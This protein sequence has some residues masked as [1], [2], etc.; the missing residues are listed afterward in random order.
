M[1]NKKNANFLFIFPFC[2]LSLR[3]PR[4]RCAY[5]KPIK[6]VSHDSVSDLYD[7]LAISHIHVRYMNKIT[8]EFEKQSQLMIDDRLGL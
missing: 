6:G 2:A 8:K 3:Y 7:T 5:Y 1:R 4:C